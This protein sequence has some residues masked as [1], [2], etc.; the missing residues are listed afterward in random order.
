MSAQAAY[1]LRQRLLR[2]LGLMMAQQRGIAATA[3]LR[4]DTS[5]LAIAATLPAY[6]FGEQ[7]DE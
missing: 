2:L 3:L 7:D 1:S 5:T 6:D 4:A